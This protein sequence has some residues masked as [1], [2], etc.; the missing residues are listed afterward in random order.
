[1]FSLNPTK[2]WNYDLTSFENNPNLVSRA[3]SNKYLV[4]VCM[5]IS[6]YSRVQA[7]TEHFKGGGQ[8]FKGRCV[9]TTRSRGPCFHIEGLQGKGRQ[10]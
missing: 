3:M 2:G 7:R 1:M 10:F 8:D 4:Y 6:F 9:P 5:Y